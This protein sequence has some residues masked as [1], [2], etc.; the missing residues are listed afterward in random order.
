MFIN[1]INFISF[2]NSYVA[3]FS[4]FTLMTGELDLSPINRY[5]LQALYP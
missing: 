3:Y 5:S 1:T 4:Y 2:Q